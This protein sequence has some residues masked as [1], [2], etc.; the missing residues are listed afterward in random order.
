MSDVAHGPRVANYSIKH[1][2][3]KQRVWFA[4]HNFSELGIQANNATIRTSI[5]FLLLQYS[6]CNLYHFLNT[7]YM[8]IL[9]FMINTYIPVSDCNVHFKLFQENQP[10][11]FGRQ[12]SK[13]CLYVNIPLTLFKLTSDDRS[14]ELFWSKFVSFPSSNLAQIILG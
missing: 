13:D 12:P 6:T 14:S 8:Y 11:N 10:V 5:K 2:M 3:S 9:S 7:L 1:I 4:I